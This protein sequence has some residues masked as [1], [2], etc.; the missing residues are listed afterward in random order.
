MA[1]REAPPQPA[2]PPSNEDRNRDRRLSAEQA[3]GGE[4]ILRTPAQRA[5]FIAG[6]LGAVVFAI[7][8]TLFGFSR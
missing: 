8:L 3:R 5:I 7:L 1:V 2:P 4:I 6:L